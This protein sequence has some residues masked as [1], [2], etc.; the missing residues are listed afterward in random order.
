M[1]S[2][3]IAVGGSVEE[4]TDLQAQ[5]AAPVSLPA[6]SYDSEALASAFAEAAKARNDGSRDEIIGAALEKANETP[7][8]AET[9]GLPPGYKRVEVEE[10]DL[11]IT[12]TRTVY[13]PS[14]KEEAEA[15]QA[16]AP[17]PIQP[18]VDAPA[19]PKGE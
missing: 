5:R 19:A 8:A 1:S 4:R 18:G 3:K 14:K 9:L 13:D 17:V 6:G 7:I 12:E 11:G 16:G 10:K 2:P 15:A